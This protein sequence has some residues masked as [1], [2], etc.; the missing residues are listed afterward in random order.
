MVEVRT[1]NQLDDLSKLLKSG[2]DVSIA[3]AYVSRRGLCRI[4]AQL[5]EASRKGNVRFLFSLDGRTTEPAAAERL[6]E[7]SSESLEV[8]Y[9][10]IPKSE[11]AIF[12]PKLFISA[13]RKRQ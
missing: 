5:K 9:F 11:H 1:A 3:V 7:L 2:G 13:T 10:D 4:E 6:L 12:H 8:R